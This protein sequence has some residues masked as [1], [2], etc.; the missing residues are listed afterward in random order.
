MT[1]T[2]KRIN[3]INILESVG[4][5]L[6]NKELIEQSKSFVFS[7]GKVF[8]YNDEIAAST[9]IDL[10]LD[11][12]VEAEALLKLLN[13]TKD[14]E[15][16]IWTTDDEL[17]I[18]GKK[19]DTGIK[20]D[21]EIKLPIDEIEIPEEFTNVPKEFSQLVR[22]ACLTASKNLSDDLLTCVHFTNNYIESCDNDRITRC[23]LGKEFEN[24]DLDVLISAKNLESIVKERIIGFMTDD[25]WAHFKT[26]E[27]VI[28]SSR[29][30]N[31]EYVDLDDFVPNKKGDKVELPEQI[32]T[33]LDRVDVF[34]KDE[35]SNEKN[36][37]VNLKEKKLVLSAQNDSGW[38]K[39]R[40]KTKYKGPSIEFTINSD[41]LRDILSMSNEVQIID[42]ILMFE[43]DSSVHLIK[44]DNDSENDDD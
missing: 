5:G 10:E 16:K 4:A 6:A 40:E 19:F 9:T 36:V 23:N 43:D 11:G 32:S 25:S 14:D 13:K 2:I 33:V 24:E 1:Q 12:A 28:L 20:L 15:I 3:L 44:L 21:S 37:H 17:R 41:F 18:K 29:L 22:L 39:E 35:V 42:D 7:D 38:I 30:Y 8:T 26:D 27:D 31:E 34:S